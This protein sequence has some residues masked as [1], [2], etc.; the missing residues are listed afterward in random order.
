MENRKKKRI[1]KWAKKRKKKKNFFCSL[2]VTC[3]LERECLPRSLYGLLCLLGK[4]LQR[5][6]KYSH[7]SWRTLDTFPFGKK[8]TYLHFFRGSTIFSLISIGVWKNTSSLDR[9][10]VL[11]MPHIN[12]ANSEQIA[13]HISSCKCIFFK[14]FKIPLI[15]YIRPSKQHPIEKPWPD[16]LANLALWPA[17]TSPLP[18][19]LFSFH[20]RSLPICCW[21]G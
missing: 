3:L 7:L 19:S 17:P 21:C 18:A 6:K 14:N 15:K 13:L 20:P 1:M 5:K 9:D 11:N 2:S 12:A 10:H 8:K 4:F 16:C